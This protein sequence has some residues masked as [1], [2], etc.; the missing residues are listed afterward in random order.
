MAQNFS[1]YLF[2]LEGRW[3]S[4]AKRAARSSGW[5]RQSWVVRDF[6]QRP[7]DWEARQACF[8]QLTERWID[9]ADHM[10]HHDQP[11]GSGA[12]DREFLT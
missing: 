10:L 2:R 7:G 3:P 11:A 8:A 6:E 9:N 12:A 5:P 4:G 1:P